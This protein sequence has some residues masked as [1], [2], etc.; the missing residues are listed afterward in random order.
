MWLSGGLRGSRA[1]AYF[2]CISTRLVKV[3]AIVVVDDWEAEDDARTMDRSCVTRNEAGAC[4]VKVCG[5]IQWPT[6]ARLDR[7]LM[8]WII[9]KLGIE[10][11][12]SN[13]EVDV[14]AKPTEGGCTCLLAWERTGGRDCQCRVGQADQRATA[15]R[16]AD[17]L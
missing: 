17:L 8:R 10:A 6:T 2:C 9:L 16:R 14:G 4:R 3:G 13:V 7:G 11:L 12:F 1:C 5:H 15:S